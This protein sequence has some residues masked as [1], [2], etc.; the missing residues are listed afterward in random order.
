MTWN[1]SGSEI[2]LHSAAKLLPI[3]MASSKNTAAHLA[4]F[5]KTR[6]LVGSVAVNLRTDPRCMCA[7]LAPRRTS[8]LPYLVS[9]CGCLVT[10][11]PA[12]RETLDKIK[13]YID[14]KQLGLYAYVDISYSNTCQYTVAT[15]EYSLQLPPKN[16]V[17]IVVFA[18]ELRRARFHG[19]PEFLR[20]CTIIK[21]LSLLILIKGLYLSHR[22]SLPY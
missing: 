1:K 13:G 10:C 2:M 4:P 6:G 12:W 9:S 8:L 19:V 14:F 18:P 7:E 22:T 3:T 16:Y 15:A 21:L 11:I 5:L 17:R 20:H